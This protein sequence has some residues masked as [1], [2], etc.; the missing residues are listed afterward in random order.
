[1]SV[2]Y[3]VGVEHEYI[4]YHIERFLKRFGRTSK[5]LIH[6]DVLNLAVG[7]VLRRDISATSKSPHTNSVF[8][9]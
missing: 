2:M 6:F 5:D 1:M 3:P 9:D 4:D 8:I 7:C